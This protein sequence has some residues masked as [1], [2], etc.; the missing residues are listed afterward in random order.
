[1]KT[2]DRHELSNGNTV[3]IVWH[4]RGKRHKTVIELSPTFGVEPILT[5]HPTI[6]SA[7]NHLADILA[8]DVCDELY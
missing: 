4:T 1:M 6:D 8:A 2:T 5:D 3:W 7:R